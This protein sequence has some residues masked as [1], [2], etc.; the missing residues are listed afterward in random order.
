MLVATCPSREELLDY[1]VGGLSE[2]AADALA[3]HLEGCQSCQAELAALPEPDDALIARLREP[4]SSDPFLDE[5]GCGEA[6]ALARAVVQRE[7]SATDLPRQLGEY[8]LMERLGSGGM[9]T[10]YKA[11]QARLDRIVALKI[12][13]RGRTDNPRAIV[14]FEREMKAIGRLD[15]AHIVRAYDAREIDGTLV[16]VMEFVDGLDL[17]EIVRRTIEARSASE[18]GIQAR[19][20][21]EEGGSSHSL[22]RRASITSVRRGIAVPD[23][24]E[25]VRQTALA[26]QCATSTPWSIAT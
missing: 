5:P 20:A 2:E 12:L 1:A 23:A 24:C 17:A 26:L 6:V 13:G 8:Q 15:H 25:L 11:R 4:L 22:A 21:S 10:V 18:A 7:A 14:R 16:L 9:G 3:S 19:S